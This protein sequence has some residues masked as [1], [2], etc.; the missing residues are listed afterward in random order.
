[1][2]YDFILWDALSITI[3]LLVAFIALLVVKFSF[4]YFQGDHKSISFLIRALFL[5]VSVI[6]MVTTDHLG[7]LLISFLI[8]NFLLVK[9]MVHKTSWQVA[10]VSGKLAARN[11]IMGGGFLCLALW[12]FYF[13]TKSFSIQYINS[14][15]TGHTLNYVGAIFL[16]LAALTQSGIW[17]IGR[18]HV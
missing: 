2:P 13:A 18:A 6:I 4:T 7:I 10:V 5:G 17:Q 9:L 1:M 12:C 14:Y 15:P 8:S 11:F 3:T 16:V